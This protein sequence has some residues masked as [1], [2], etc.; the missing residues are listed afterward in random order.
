MKIVA[1]IA[2][3]EPTLYTVQ[4]HGN[5][6]DEFDIAFDDW[7]DPEWLRLFFEENETDLD[8]YNKFHGT[9][10]TIDEAVLKTL[11]DAEKLEDL[12]Y[13]IACSGSEYLQDMF[14]QLHEK[15]DDY[16][17]LQKSKAKRSWLRLYAIRI[18]EHLY[19][20]TGGAIKLTRKM[21]EREHTKLELD[22]LFQVKEFLKRKGLVNKEAFEKLE[23]G[24]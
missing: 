7:N 22:K 21:N 12:L 15:E 18:D 13:D 6:K 23:L 8:A 10:Y 2:D 17:V 4:Y 5:D 19:V 1:I 11:D 3:P 9:N 16:Y 14:E 20:F 24:L